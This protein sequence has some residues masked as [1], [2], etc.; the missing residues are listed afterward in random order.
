MN[1]KTQDKLT[2]NENMAKLKSFVTNQ[3]TRSYENMYENER[4]QI[5]NLLVNYLKQNNNK[6][7][8]MDDIT[9]SFAEGKN[10]IFELKCDNELTKIRS[11]TLI[12]EYMCFDKNLVEVLNNRKSFNS[13]YKCFGRS[14]FTMSLKIGE[15]Q[16]NSDDEYFFR[17]C[18]LITFTP[19][20]NNGR[21]HQNITETRKSYFYGDNK[22]DD[23]DINITIDAINSFINNDITDNNGDVN[24]NIDDVN[25]DVNNNIDD[26]NDDSITDSNTILIQPAYNFDLIR[27]IGERM[28]ELG[29]DIDLKKSFVIANLEFDHFDKFIK[30]NTFGDDVDEGYE[31][32]GGLYY[33]IRLIGREQDGKFSFFDPKEFS[34]MNMPNMKKGKGYNTDMTYK[35]TTDENNQL[36]EVLKFG[37]DCTIRYKM[38]FSELNHVFLYCDTRVANNHIQKPGNR[39]FHQLMIEGNYKILFNEFIRTSALEMAIEI[40]KLVDDFN[41]HFRDSQAQRKKIISNSMDKTQ[42]KKLHDATYYISFYYDRNFTDYIVKHAQ[43]KYKFEN[44]FILIE[45]ILEE[46]CSDDLITDEIN[47]KIN[48]IFNVKG[49]KFRYG[50]GSYTACSCNL[51]NSLELL[52]TPPKHLLITK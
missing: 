22:V 39:V 43:H 1:R 51:T 13:L 48:D 34:K 35:F 50:P 2:I 30:K 23:N 27:K 24:N 47:D 9:S 12:C 44:R 49:F 41:H 10:Y 31:D 4:S 32:R 26:V 46:L 19:N 7:R 11:S 14:D 20:T 42:M 3:E 36:N 37:K 40:P 29:I 33:P 38:E 5:I 25:D 15:Y 18:I 28:V 17:K 52:F 8:I 45:T 21:K 6:K 16:L